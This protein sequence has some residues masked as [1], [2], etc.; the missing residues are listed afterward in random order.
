M[1]SS[2]DKD[3]MKFIFLLLIISSQASAKTWTR[4]E[5]LDFVNLSPYYVDLH[6]KS[7][8][9]GIFADDAFIEDPVGGY[10]FKKNTHSH[11]FQENQVEMF[12]NAFIAK[13]N[14][15]FDI[16]QDIVSHLTV[17][18]D[19]VVNANIPEANATVLTPAHLRYTLKEVDGKL[20]VKSLEAYW[21]MPTVTKETLS[22]GKVGTKIMSVQLGNIMSALGGVGLKHFLKA[23]LVGVQGR[24]QKLVNKTILALNASNQKLFLSKFKKNSSIFFNHVKMTP[25]SLLESNPVI[26]NINKVISSGSSVA[27]NCHYNQQP[28]VI[29]VSIKMGKISKFEVFSD[30]T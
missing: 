22:R 24:G 16:K 13:N 3:L 1:F 30:Q 8:W 18:R 6:D 12:W 19:S 23:S 2:Q 17:I 29:I 7:G 15:H 5:V 14:I 26:T 25:A 21:N 28:A 4:E 9:V 10:H 20:K 27:L 11:R